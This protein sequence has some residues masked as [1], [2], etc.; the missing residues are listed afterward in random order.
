MGLIV[1]SDCVPS[2]LDASSVSCACSD[3][4]VSGGA[5][6]GVVGGTGLTRACENTGAD[7]VDADASW[8]T[9]SRYPGVAGSELR[10]EMESSRWDDG[11]GDESDSFL[12]PL[13]LA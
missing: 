10:G 5:V 7:T 1:T 11:R 9:A 4:R 13:V 6:E 2:C 12:E 8:A 3:G